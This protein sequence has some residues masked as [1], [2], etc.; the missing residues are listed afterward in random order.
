MS[1][2]QQSDVLHLTDVQQKAVIGWMLKEREF[3]L[4]CRT[5]LKATHFSG[6]PLLGEL[7]NYICA[8]ANTYDRSPSVAELEGEIMSHYVSAKDFNE[9]KGMLSVCVASTQQI[10][11]P[12]LTER[13]TSWLRF[14]L[15]KNMI[16]EAAVRYN[17]KQYDT[18]REFIEAAIREIKEADFHQDEKVSFSNLQ[19]KLIERIANHDNCCTI[20]HADFDD[21]LRAGAKIPGGDMRFIK[22]SSTGGLIPGDL[23]VLMGPSNAGKTTSIV[24]VIKQNILMGKFVLLVTHEQKDDDIRFKIIQSFMEDHWDKF[25]PKTPR[26]EQEQKLAWIERILEDRLVY[27]SWIK[28]GQ[29]FVE[30]V[31]AMIQMKQEKF[32]AQELKLRS[33]FHYGEEIKPIGKGFDLLVNDYPG[34]LKSRL[35][36][37]SRTTSAY[38][39]KGWVYNEFLNLA[40]LYKFHVLVPAQTNRT[41]YQT[42]QGAN[43]RMIDQGDIADSF[44]I[45]TLADNIIT[46]N[47]G[48]KDQLGS[49]IKYYISKSRSG[50]THY[51]FVS[52]TRFDRS[53]A[54]G[55]NLAAHV[56]KPGEEVSDEVVYQLLGVTERKQAMAPAQ[57][58]ALPQDILP[59]PDSKIP[60]TTN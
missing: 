26:P 32:A 25:D 55:P 28:P 3:M 12:P 49:T 6:S 48:P 30:D 7:F 9:R 34:K 4:K 22:T 23:T 5:S 14:V 60:Q 52:R 21:V 10:S 35:Y 11:L 44:G 41:G 18:A 38:D 56:F 53:C 45:S 33:I 59:M 37:N 15:L 29:M 43:K 17:K 16:T 58:L 24:S 8:F 40:R 57:P 42:A 46:I 27:V 19:E 47:R 50:P 1:E 20:G 2:T 54:I 39:E 13:M 36:M 31:A 51:T